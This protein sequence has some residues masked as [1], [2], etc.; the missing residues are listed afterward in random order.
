MTEWQSLLENN[1]LPI[2]SMSRVHFDGNAIKKTHNCLWT[3]TQGS[4]SLFSKI[5][6]LFR[7]SQRSDYGETTILKLPR[8]MFNGLL[9]VAV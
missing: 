5:C 4:I 1:Q 9:W 7:Y 3:L 6:K 2:M 8:Y